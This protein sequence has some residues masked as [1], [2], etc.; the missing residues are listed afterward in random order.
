[1]YV[2]MR[3]QGFTVRPWRPDIRFGVTREDDTL[4]LT[5]QA[6]YDWQG[7]LCADR[8]RHRDWHH[9]PWDYPRINQFQEWFTIGDEETAVLELEN[10][11]PVTVTGAMLR[12]YPLTVS[13]GQTLRVKLSGKSGIEHAN[14]GEPKHSGMTET[15]AQP[16]RELALPIPLTSDCL[17]SW[18]N[19]LRNR[20]RTLLRVPEQLPD[21][22]LD[23]RIESERR[24]EDGTVDRLLTVAGYT[25]R[26]IPLRA[27]VPAE[28]LPASLP[29]VVCLGGH[30]STLDTVFTE[31]RYKQFA[32]ALAAR[33]IAVVAVDIS[34][35]E[36]LDPDTTL[37]GERLL[38]TCR[39][40]DYLI[41]LP[42][43]DSRR[44]GCAGLSLG[45]EMA[46]WLGAMDERVRSVCAMGFLTWMN[47]ME[48]NHCMCWKVE[49]IREACDFPDIY[50]LIA[51]RPLMLQLGRQEP[52]D[53]FNVIQGESAF[54][55]LR[56]AWLAAGQPQNVQFLVHAGGHEVDLPG[57]LSFFSGNW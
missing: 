44:I 25:G 42:A 52:F 18:Q 49:G 2:L 24:A 14:A 39:A 4:F 20:L 12:H 38:D 40:V 6:D 37:M 7:E 53:Q 28:T 35:H 23:P 34:R 8:P 26:R 11:S 3:T 30:G 33:G 22:P 21:V 15:A 50:A 31:P 55:E 27:R 36:T 19:S 41:S 29:G 56:R 9:L 10:L 48:R 57:L 1:M 13:G 47:Q 32:A 5:V 54:R 16:W 45:G 46:M 17:Q 43:V 51:P